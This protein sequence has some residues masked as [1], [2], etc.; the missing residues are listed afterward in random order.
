MLWLCAP[1]QRTW[2]QKTHSCG[3][4]QLQMIDSTSAFCITDLKTV[5]EAYTIAHINPHT[6]AKYFHIFSESSPLNLWALFMVH[7]L[8]HIWHRS[9]GKNVEMLIINKCIATSNKGSNG[10]CLLFA[11]TEQRVPSWRIS[12]PLRLP[13]GGRWKV[14]ESKQKLCSWVVFAFFL[15]T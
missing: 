3:W 5:F 1:I 14:N 8:G 15:Q 13:G 6:S 7:I 10:V 2:T 4:L 11:H 9:T 12:L